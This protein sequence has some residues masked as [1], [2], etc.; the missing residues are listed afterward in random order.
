ML[1]HICQGACAAGPD[2]SDPRPAWKRLPCDPNVEKIADTSPETAVAR[3]EMYAPR[4]RTIQMLPTP[5][6][7][8]ADHLSVNRHRT[9]TLPPGVAIHSY[10]RSNPDRGRVPINA[11]RNSGDSLLMDACQ[12][13]GRF[14]KM[15]MVQRSSAPQTPTGLRDFQ[16]PGASAGDGGRIPP[17]RRAREDHLKLTAE[18]RDAAVGENPEGEVGESR[19]QV[20]K[21][22]VFPAEDTIGPLIGPAFQCEGA[23]RM[24]RRTSPATEEL[25]EHLGEAKRG[26]VVSLGC[27]IF[28]NPESDAIIADRVANPPGNIPDIPAF[29][30]ATEIMAIP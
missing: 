25:Q 18:L 4:R 20:G 24:W 7:G 23:E 22:V 26:H 8:L 30:T 5:A 9:V 14:P 17:I 3:E 29:M 19:V 6:Y 2:L 21:F 28:D 16:C 13:I 27:P 12:L 10:R 11:A 1:Q 15:A